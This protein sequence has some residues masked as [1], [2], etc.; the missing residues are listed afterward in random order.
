MLVPWSRLPSNFRVILAPQKVRS[1][2]TLA[3][4]K[5]LPEDEIQSYMKR[6]RSRW[7]PG[8]T[9]WKIE[10]WHKLGFQKEPK[11]NE[12]SWK[13]S[14]PNKIHLEKIFVKVCPIVNDRDTRDKMCNWEI[15]IDEER[16]DCPFD[17]NFET[18]IT[19]RFDKS[20][21]FD[22]YLQLTAFISYKL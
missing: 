14:N 15:E 13:F 20:Y 19:G 10:C 2:F 6:V 16:V 12:L 18:E 4:D 21:Y 17:E 3:R 8:K 22:Y 7:E 9:E 11:I 1:I 5:S